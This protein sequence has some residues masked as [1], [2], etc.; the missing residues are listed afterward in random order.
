MRKAVLSVGR[1]SESVT[2]Q[3]NWGHRHQGP[4]PVTNTERET[5]IDTLS[6]IGGVGGY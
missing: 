3:G 4:H 1:V 6:N 2:N 5:I